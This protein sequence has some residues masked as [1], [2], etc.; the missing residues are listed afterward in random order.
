MKH[1]LLAA[2]CLPALAVAQAPDV[3]IKADLRFGISAE[4]GGRSYLRWFDIMGRTSTVSLMFTLEPGF[5]AVVSQRL[6]TIPNSGDREFF[7]EYYVEDPGLWRVGKQ[8]L[9]FGRE[10]VIRESARGVRGDTNLFLEG[11]P[12]VVAAC[13]E[14]PQLPRGIV[15]RVGGRI[16]VSAAVGEHFGISGSSL[17]VIRRPE[18]SPGKGAGYGFLLGADFSKRWGRLEASGE[19]VVLRRGNSSVD[20]ETEVSDL[21]FTVRNPEGVTATAAWSRDWEAG[22]NFFRVEATLKVYRGLMLEP[23][24]RWQGRRIWLAGISARAKF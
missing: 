6:Q 24:V 7:E 9:P 13:D 17:T 23:I 11:L 18:D 5:K 15:A 12:V 21:A 22:Q 19:F 20:R 2:L 4:T 16:G 14:G 1:C 3:L 8:I 10:F